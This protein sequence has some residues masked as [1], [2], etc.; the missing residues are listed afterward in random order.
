VFHSTPFKISTIT[1]LSGV[2]ADVNL[3]TLFEQVE[4]EDDESVVGPVYIEY[5]R[6]KSEHSFRGSHHKPKKNTA[7]ANIAQ[8]EHG[9]SSKVKRFDNQATLDY[10]IAPDYYINTKVFNNGTVHMTGIKSIPDGNRVI[11]DLINRIEKVVA[12]TKVAQAAA[13]ANANANTDVG[14]GIDE[15][16]II[17][18]GAVLSAQPV[19]V[20]LINSDFRINFKLKREILY[21][22]LVHK[23]KNKCTY[24]P[25]IYPGVKL[26]YFWNSATKN[27]VHNGNCQCSRGQCR[28]KGKGATEGDC[29]KVTIGIF[30]SGCVI[31]TGASAV[32]QIDDCYAYICRIMRESINEIRRRTYIIPDDETIKALLGV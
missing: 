24:E 29:K 20:H 15:A 8:N 26:Q 12:A 1:A 10:K 18:A 32:E 25:C 28:G 7:N 17:P 13:D 6:T 23:Y 2:G 19:T 9:S 22:I 14:T 4:L 21:D 30:Q 5:G 27:D 16:R 11:S 3:Q 31:I